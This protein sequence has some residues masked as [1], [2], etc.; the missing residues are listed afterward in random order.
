MGKNG[1][2]MRVSDNCKE[3]DECTGLCTCCYPGYGEPIKG[4]CPSTPPTS[5]PVDD[6]CAKY[7][8]I[9]AK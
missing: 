9:D 7:G 5:I 8:Y 4:V 3:W 1:K 6:H 2:C